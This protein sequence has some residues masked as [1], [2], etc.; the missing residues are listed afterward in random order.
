MLHSSWHN[1][2]FEILENSLSKKQ[3]HILLYFIS[4]QFQ[5]KYILIL[6]FNCCLCGTNESKTS[7]F[8]RLFLDNVVYVFIYR[9]LS[10]QARF[11]FTYLELNQILKFVECILVLNKEQT[12]TIS[13]PIDIIFS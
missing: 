4:V 11:A 12:H 3:L 8:C 2:V 5:E 13:N 9:A 7:H 6:A 1:L 10:A